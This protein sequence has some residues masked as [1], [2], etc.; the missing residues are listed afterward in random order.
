MLWSDVQSSNARGEL[1]F[2]I[3]LT[4]RLLLYFII[5][6]INVTSVVFAIIFVQD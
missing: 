2:H 1:Y 5:V 4:I 6:S 3:L